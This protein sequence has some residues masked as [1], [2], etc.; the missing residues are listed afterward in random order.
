[1]TQSGFCFRLIFV[2]SHRALVAHRADRLG[3]GYF[4][5]LSLFGLGFPFFGFLPQLPF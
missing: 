4:Y 5:F 1:M 2:L 3:S